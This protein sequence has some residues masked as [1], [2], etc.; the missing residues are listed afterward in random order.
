[1]IVYLLIP[2]ASEK[3]ACGYEMQSRFYENLKGISYE[4]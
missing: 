2:Q 3:F 4:F 1:M